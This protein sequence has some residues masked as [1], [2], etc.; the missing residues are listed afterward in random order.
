MGL[1]LDRGGLGILTALLAVFAVMAGLIGSSARDPGC[2][3]SGRKYPLVLI[4]R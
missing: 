3:D 4:S 1:K 2:A